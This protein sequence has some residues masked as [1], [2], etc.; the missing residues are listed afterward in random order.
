MKRIVVA[1]IS[2]DVGK[3]VV[4]AIIAEAI[5]GFYWKPIQCGILKDREWI[6][7]RLSKTDR[8]YPE[9]VDLQTPC[10]PH[11]AARIENRCIDKE[12]LLLPDCPGVLIIEGTGGILTPINETESWIDVALEWN[13]EWIIVHRHYL[14]S[15]NHFLLTI[16]TLKHY[17]VP[18]L[19][20]IFNGEGDFKTEKMLLQRA[21]TE[22]LGRLEW[23]MQLTAEV[24]LKI[25]K[26]WNPTL[27]LALGL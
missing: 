4:S 2:T 1:G 24:I 19:G 5:E 10:S 15:L 27:Q 6:Q 16:E 13:A 18:L 17:Q 8:C 21:Q 25:A 9:G 11:E 26:E 22:C 12:Q 3:T 14:G 7:E 20:V 23:Q